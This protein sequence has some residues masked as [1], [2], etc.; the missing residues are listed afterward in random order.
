M[1]DT[2]V[3]LALWIGRYVLMGGGEDVRG[4]GIFLVF[5]KVMIFIILG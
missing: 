4:F 1:G 2:S 5:V 3:H